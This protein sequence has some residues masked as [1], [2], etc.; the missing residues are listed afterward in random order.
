V[1]GIHGLRGCHG[2]GHSVGSLQA[3]VGRFVCCHPSRSPRIVRLLG[4]EAAGPAAIA[5]P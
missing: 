4:M 2:Y 1:T 3:R 5:P